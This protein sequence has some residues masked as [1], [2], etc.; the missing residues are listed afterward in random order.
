VDITHATP[1]AEREIFEIADQH[2]GQPVIVSHSGVR[3]LPATPTTSQTGQSTESPLPVA[4]SESS[5]VRT[6]CGNQQSN[7]LGSRHLDLVF[8]AIDHIVKVTG[9]VDSVGIGSDLDGFIQPVEEVENLA[10]IPALV[11]AIE[12]RYGAEAAEKILWGNVLRRP[13]TRLAVK[14]ALEA[15][16]PSRELHF[17]GPFT[18]FD[19]SPD[20]AASVGWDV[21]PPVG[22]RDSAPGFPKGR[23][24]TASG[25]SQVGDHTSLMDRRLQG[26]FIGT[27]FP[28]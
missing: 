6:G 2:P 23:S 19:C 11:S 12:E 22:P 26:A 7:C 3:G 18:V 17:R 10:Q 15:A 5:C 25:R 13:E 8:R 9:S 21:L 20:R 16:V 27:Y 14:R 24:R 1:Q 28:P 4:L